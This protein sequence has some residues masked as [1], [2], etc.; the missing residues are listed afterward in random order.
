LSLDRDPSLISFAEA[1]QH[2]NYRRPAVTD[3]NVVIIKNGRHPLQ[4][5]TIDHYVPNPT[6]LVGGRGIVDHMSEDEDDES[7]DGNGQP[8]KKGTRKDAAE[9]SSETDVGLDGEH[10]IMVLTGT[11]ASGK[12]VYGKAVALIVYM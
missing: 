3:D 8:R 9:Q 1:A 6:K 10:S 12:S 2:Y 11:N 5:L 7:E 4:E